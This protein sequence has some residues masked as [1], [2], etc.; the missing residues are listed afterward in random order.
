MLYVGN[1][2]SLVAYYPL[3]EEDSD[4]SYKKDELF[5]LI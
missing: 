3:M 1:Q 5:Y 2:D 4:N